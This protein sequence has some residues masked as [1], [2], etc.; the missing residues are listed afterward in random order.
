MDN[1]NNIN[2]NNINN[3]NTEKTTFMSRVKGFVKSHK[4]PT[5]ITALVLVLA[6]GTGVV[7][8]ITKSSGNIGEFPTFSSDETGSDI[9]V[10][11]IEADDETSS[12]TET[13]AGDDTLSTV[14]TQ[15]PTPDK[16]TSSTVSEQQPSTSTP[17]YPTSSGTATSTP[18]TT[19]P[20]APSETPSTTPSTPSTPTTS[21]WT[22]PDPSAHPLDRGGNPQYACLCKEI[23]DS[24]I[25]QY[26][27]YLEHKDDK[28]TLGNS[29]PDCGREL[30]NGYNNTCL[31][32]L[33][34]GTWTCHHYD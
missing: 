11:P 4:I 14:V 6:I 10:P 16:S 13:D 3:E 2:N 22:C 21:T 5:V 12:K 18:S 23:H 32:R 8:G 33:E 7:F 17:Q 30:G 24:Y 20:S 27:L 31:S 9:D 19:T 34:N 29:C 1:N 26:Q 25:I 15:T 28:S